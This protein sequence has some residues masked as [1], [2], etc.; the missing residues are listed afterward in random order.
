[1]SGSHIL[2]SGA[3]LQSPNY[4]ASV[5]AGEL[6]PQITLNKFRTE[7]EEWTWWDRLQIMYKMMRSEEH[8]NNPVEEE[9]CDEKE[10]PTELFAACNE[11]RCP[12]R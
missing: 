4:V 6:V 12:A 5:E 7:E 9:F 10:K 1:M 3:M 2:F 11:E 8:G